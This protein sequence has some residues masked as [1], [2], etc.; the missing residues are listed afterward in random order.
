MSCCTL[1]HRRIGYPLQQHIIEWPALLWLALAA[2]CARGFSCRH[3]SS[4]RVL[5]WCAQVP[6]GRARGDASLALAYL[7]SHVTVSCWMHVCFIDADRPAKC[8]AQSVEGGNSDSAGMGDAFHEHTQHM[9][10]AHA[11]FLAHWLHLVD[12][13]EGDLTAKRAEIWAMPGK[14]CLHCCNRCRTDKR[15]WEPRAHATHDSLACTDSGP[16]AVHLSTWMQ[17]AQT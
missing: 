1:L 4:L 9:T 17:A 8:C 15:V 2:R 12:L 6:C 10:P 14:M 13:E 5:C 3:T 7:D 16:L 11:Q